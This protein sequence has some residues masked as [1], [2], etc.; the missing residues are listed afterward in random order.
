MEYPFHRAE[1]CADLGVRVHAV[2]L[3]AVEVGEGA[4]RPEVAIAGG[5][6]FDPLVERSAPKGD[7]V[8]GEFLRLRSACL[9]VMAA[10]LTRRTCY[11]YGFLAHLFTPSFSLCRTPFRNGVPRIRFQVSPVSLKFP[12]AGYCF[13]VQGFR[14]P[15]RR[16]HDPSP[17]RRPCFAQDAPSARTR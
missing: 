12:S 7:E 14:A 2:V 16:Q 10:N 6:A 4:L 17:S 11:N 15:H 9:F 13:L 8:F 1:R 5:I 3:H